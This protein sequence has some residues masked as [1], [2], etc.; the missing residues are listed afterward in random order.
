MAAEWTG[1]RKRELQAVILTFSGMFIDENSLNLKAWRKL[2]NSYGIAFQKEWEALSLAGE[3]RQMAKAV[4]RHLG[5]NSA[6]SHGAWRRLIEEKNRFFLDALQEVDE[7]DLQPGIAPLLKDLKKNGV[8]IAVISEFENTKQLIEQLEVGDF[9]NVTIDTTAD[10]EKGLPASELFLAALEKLG[11]SP[12]QTVVIESADS[13]IQCKEKTKMAVIAVGNC[14]GRADRRFDTTSEI[15][16][17]E[18][19]KVLRHKQ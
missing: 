10:H 17:E 9:V 19:K 1:G 11:V 4:T 7:N 3:D 2:C 18:V 16:Y 14:G 5:N 8:K 12:V 6:D 15:T 13:A